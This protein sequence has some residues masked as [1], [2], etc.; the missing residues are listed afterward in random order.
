MTSSEGRLVFAAE[1]TGEDAA[2]VNPVNVDKV[3]ANDRACYFVL[4]MHRSGTSSL[5]GAFI[6]LGIA[7]PKTL[8][9]ANEGN[10]AG[11][12]ESRPLILF[13]DELLASAGSRWDDWRAFNG[14]WYETPVAAQFRERG[15]QLLLSEFGHAPLFVF[16]D[17]RNCRIARFWLDIFAEMG[18]RPR[19]VL[20]VRSPLEVAQSHRA[21]DGFQL[22]KGM[23]LWLRHVLDAEA[24][25]RNLPR[26]IV[27]WNEFLQHW[28]Q[29]ISQMERM[30]G[31]FPANTDLAAVEV[32]KFLRKDLKHQEVTDDE[33]TTNELVHPWVEQAYRALLELASKPSSKTARKTL[34]HIR[35]RLDEAASLFGSVVAD[36]E[37]AEIE[38]RQEQLAEREVHA[39]TSGE[40]AVLADKQ[41][42]TLVELEAE[43]VTN[44]DLVRQL[45]EARKIDHMDKLIEA[46]VGAWRT[47]AAE[48]QA[49]EAVAQQLASLTEEHHQQLL[50]L[51]DE[52]ARNREL[53]Q[54]LAEAQAEIE[55]KR[56]M[57]WAESE[58]RDASN[59]ELEYQR[60]SGRVEIEQ[61]VSQDRSHEWSGA[62]IRKERRNTQTDKAQAV[63]AQKL[64]ITGDVRAEP[65]TDELRDSIVVAKERKWLVATTYRIARNIIGRSYLV[66]RSL[67]LPLTVRRKFSRAAAQ[68]NLL[69]FVHEGVAA[70]SASRAA[71]T[72][73]DLVTSLSAPESELRKEVPEFSVV[74]PVYDRTWELRE[75][76]ESIIAQEGVSFEVILVLDGSPAETIS[77]VDEFRGDPRV[78][79]FSYPKASGNAVRGRNKGILEASGK[80]IA[81]LDSD[82]IAIS[83]RLY[84]TAQAFIETGADVIYGGWQAILDGSREIEGL[85]DGQIVLSPSCD[86]E[87]LKSACV[88]CQSTVAVRRKAFSLSGVLK[89]QMK[90][91]EDHELWARMAHFGCKFVA[92]PNV[93]SKLRIHA[94][95]NELNFKEG[96]AYWAEQFFKEFHIRTPEF[97]KV[98][99]VLPGVGIG[100]GV[101][102]VFKHAMMLLAFGHDVTILNIGEHS[103]TSWYPNLTVPVYGMRDISPYTLAN[104]DLIFA[105][106]WQ[107][108]DFVKEIPALR[109]LYFVQSDERRF[110]QDEATRERV[111]KG[112]GSSFEFL[113]EAHW[114]Q[115]LLAEEFGQSA[116]YVPNGLDST[117]FHSKRRQVGKRQRKRVLLEGPI[118]VPFKGMVDAYNAV[119]DL[120]CDVWIVSSSGRP[121]QDWR[122]DRFF[123]GVEFGRMSELYSSCDV[124]LKMSRIE[125]FFGPPMEAMACG[126]AVVV[127]RVTGYDEY[128][129]DGQNALVV[130]AGDVDGATNAVR[131]LL[132]DDELRDKMVEQGK[133]TA[134]EWTWERS[135]IAMNDLVRG[136][137]HTLDN[138]STV[139]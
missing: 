109:K 102:V 47:L 41:K 96:D 57:A 118:N 58:A 129:I 11:H 130:E 44:Q 9:G 131:R 124:F 122:V 24:V 72:A 21:R 105:T 116:A 33:L 28:Q 125:G 46:E 137:D 115:R 80:Y 139:L 37:A 43:R 83:N 63:S 82:D 134:S 75:A 123:E 56:K 106:G 88:P 51:H 101:A 95:N 20:P 94:G 14:A 10:T 113:T 38:A 53:E 26:V 66:Y 84:L 50:Q 34:D 16:K 1:R 18:I 99:F 117:I 119:R 22:R 3:E 49:H 12:W 87:M 132:E 136:S 31:L 97:K 27:D 127:G 78:K 59:V 70:F 73:A 29:S 107:T 76:V 85:Q 39:S 103:D 40:M 138:I 111:A 110:V 52:Q 86:I 104:I 67:P 35:T 65:A 108:V 7:A 90:Y 69:P 15:K 13:H 98:V 45:T 133:K 54:L 55:H 81:F 60:G 36:A 93:L 74:I 92:L 42:Q 112:Y 25:S 128:I 64:E 91:R 71:I 68:A 62:P 23:L 32:E 114:I 48:K 30:L 126:C 100:G 89:P 77:V 8:L 19:I 61:P 121:P 135:F 4:G 120:D 17:P 6:K 2:E 5:A 79:I